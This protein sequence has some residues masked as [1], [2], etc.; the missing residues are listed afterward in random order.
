MY[1]N[2]MLDMFSIEYIYYIVI[3][4]TE[5]KQPNKKIWI[6]VIKLL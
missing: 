4:L 5:Y 1:N 3:H 6:I 2:L